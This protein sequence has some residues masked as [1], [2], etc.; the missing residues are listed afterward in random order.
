MGAESPDLVCRL[1][2]VRHHDRRHARRRSRPDAGMRVFQGQAEP[3]G[4]AQPLGRVQVRVWR[5]LAGGVVPVRYHGMEPAVQGVRCQVVLHRFVPG[6]RGYGAGQAQLVQEVDEF[7][8][9]WLQ[10]EA[11]VCHRD[12]VLPHSLPEFVHRKGRAVM[13]QQ[14]A[15]VHGPGV[16]HHA[17]EHGGKHIVAPLGRRPGERFLVERLGV[18]QQAVHVE[19][20]GSRHMGKLHHRPVSDAN[21]EHNPGRLGLLQ[22]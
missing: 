3:R 7:E 16:P 20:H 19:H 9:A 14:L 13:V 15:P 4:H 2:Q 6:R 11:G 22:P 17:E 1:Q 12:E 8:D 10:A 21:P 18:E 5:G